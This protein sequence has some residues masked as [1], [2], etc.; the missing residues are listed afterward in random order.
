MPLVKCYEN[1]KTWNRLRSWCQLYILLNI[2]QSS[3]YCNIQTFQVSLHWC[4]LISNAPL[5][6][7][8]EAA[9]LIFSCTQMSLISLWSLLGHCNH[10]LLFFRTHVALGGNSEKELLVMKTT[11]RKMTWQLYWTTQ[12]EP[13]LKALYGECYCWVTL[14]PLSASKTFHPQ[15]LLWSEVWHQQN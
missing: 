13:S 10:H 12:W 1:V 2:L 3:A 7:L 6:T 5:S 8:W 15:N 14:H 11:S 4:R 9:V